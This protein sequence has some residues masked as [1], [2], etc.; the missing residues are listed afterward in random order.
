MA[1]LERIGRKER[2][3]VRERAVQEISETVWGGENR[4]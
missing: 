4:E 3:R 1:A 2:G